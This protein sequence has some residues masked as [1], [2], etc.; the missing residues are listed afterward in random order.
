ML[1]AKAGNEWGHPKAERVIK[2]VAYH[3]EDKDQGVIAKPGPGNRDTL[4]AKICEVKQ[5]AGEEENEHKQAETNKS[6]GIA[7]VL[8]KIIEAH[9]HK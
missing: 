9:Y 5:S 7:E 1:A 8:R 4:D 2:Q 6:L 3:T